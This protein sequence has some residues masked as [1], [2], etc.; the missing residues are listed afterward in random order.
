MLP[1]GSY[2]V[3]IRAEYPNVP[4]TLG[5][6]AS[7][8]GELGGDLSS[9]DLVEADRTR[10][11][12]DLTVG[13]RDSKHAVTI[14]DALKKRIKGLAIRSASDR[15]FLAHLGGKIE[16]RNRVPVTTRRDL[17][18]VYTPGVARVSRAISMDPEAAW[19]LTIKR[20]TVAIVTDG[21]ASAT[22]AR[23]QRFP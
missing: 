5:R 3:T 8:I 22:S 12:R 15:V 16:I 14:L 18:Q 20:N 23:R 7:V 1:G 21:S 2:S 9:I 19:T 13:V 10:M 11:I 6:V 17:S 4:G